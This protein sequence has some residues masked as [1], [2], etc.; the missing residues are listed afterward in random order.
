MTTVTST[1]IPFEMSLTSAMTTGIVLASLGLF[2]CLCTAHAPSPIRVG[3]TFP[4]G[5][6][7]GLIG[8]T[9]FRCGPSGFHF[10]EL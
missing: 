8:S 5:I 9:G 2:G 10:Q 6:G 7:N 4:S 3:Y 1:V